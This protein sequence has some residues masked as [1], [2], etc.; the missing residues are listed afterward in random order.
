MTAQPCCTRSPTPYTPLC[1]QLLSPCHLCL[2][3][4]TGYT[5]HFCK[6]LGSSHTCSYISPQR[7]C[8]HSNLHPSHA[9]LLS[10][11][12]RLYSI[13]SHCQ[14]HQVLTC[15]NRQLSQP[16]CLPKVHSKACQLLCSLQPYQAR[17]CRLHLQASLN[18]WKFCCR[19]LPGVPTPRVTAHMVYWRSLS[20]I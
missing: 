11:L 16:A 14:N 12:P 18:S 8:N 2:R 4:R 5:T 10:Q 3:L 15:N 7:L 20:L 13:W 1:H 17:R 9:H 6:H 19:G